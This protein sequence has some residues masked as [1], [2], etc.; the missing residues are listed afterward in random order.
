MAIGFGYI[1][2][3]ILGKMHCCDRSDIGKLLKIF[4]RIF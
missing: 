1:E 2:S 4:N 3:E